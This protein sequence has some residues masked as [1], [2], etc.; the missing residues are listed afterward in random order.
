MIPAWAEIPLYTNLSLLE[1]SVSSRMPP[2]RHPSGRQQQAFSHK[3]QITAKPPQ[4]PKSKRTSELAKQKH[5]QEKRSSR[6]IRKEGT[7]KSFFNSDQITIPSQPN[8]QYSQPAHLRYPPSHQARSHKRSPSPN[9]IQLHPPSSRRG[10]E[11][12]W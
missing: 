10:W 2:D 8:Y 6:S 1:R 7:I 12:L 4:N 11:S 9:D 3:S 5:V